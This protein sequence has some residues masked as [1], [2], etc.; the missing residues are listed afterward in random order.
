MVHA[1]PVKQ[2]NSEQL[3]QVQLPVRFVQLVMSK[4]ALDNHTVSLAT[5]ENTKL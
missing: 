4:T 1:K 3:R 5:K 2:V